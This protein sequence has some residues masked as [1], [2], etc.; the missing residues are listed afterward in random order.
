LKTHSKD[1]LPAF[2]NARG[3][4]QYIWVY[5]RNGFAQGAFY[6]SFFG[7]SQAIYYRQVRHIPIYAFTFGAAYAAFHAS[8]AYFR[9]EI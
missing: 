2:V 8:S 9:N 4:N 3:D 5:T 7:A 1:K 6:G